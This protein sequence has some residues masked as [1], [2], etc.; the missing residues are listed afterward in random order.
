MSANVTR[1]LILLGSYL[2]NTDKEFFMN[3]Y[4]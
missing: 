1:N 3:K 4:Y 2:N